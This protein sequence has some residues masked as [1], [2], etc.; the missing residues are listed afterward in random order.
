M[1]PITSHRAA[2]SFEVKMT[3]QPPY[4][5]TDGVTLGRI[6]VAKTFQGQLEGTSTLEMLTG[7]SPVKGSGAYVAIERFTGKLDG[8]SGSFVMAHNGTMTRGDAQLTVSIVP[9]T[10]TGEIEGIAGT[11]EI[12]IVDG[13]HFYT[14]DYTLAEAP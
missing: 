3:P 8:R 6:S 9:D 10:G 2:G 7:M 4:D 1:S 5:T 14:L 11:L 13:K 12:D